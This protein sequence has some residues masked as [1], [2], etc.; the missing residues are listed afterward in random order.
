MV[1]RGSN[2][3]SW[4]LGRELP[5][6]FPYVGA[7][8]A[9]PSGAPAA[10]GRDYKVGPVIMVDVQEAAVAIPTFSVSSGADHSGLCF[11]AFQSPI[12][13]AVKLSVVQS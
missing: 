7:Q 4:Q 8:G 10:Q 6:C 9:G 1:S 2:L 11:L 13:K 12:H 3:P 5:L